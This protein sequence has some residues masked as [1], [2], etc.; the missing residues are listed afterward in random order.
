M[1]KNLHFTSSCLRVT[2]KT[3]TNVYSNIFRGTYDPNLAFMEMLCEEDIDPTEIKSYSTNL[4]KSYS[5]E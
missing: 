4:I 1:A 3:D 5:N 2:I